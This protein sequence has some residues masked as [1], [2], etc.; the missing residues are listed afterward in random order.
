MRLINIYS[1]S[2][3]L[4]SRFFI[5]LA[6]CFQKMGHGKIYEPI[7]ISKKLYKSNREWEKRWKAI[8]EIIKE[9][10]IKNLMDIGCSEGWFLRRAAEDFSCF[11]IGIEASKPTLMLAETARLYDLVE[12]MAIIKCKLNADTATSLP[13][14]DAILCLSVLHHVVRE[15]G[16]DNARKFLKALATKTNKV[17]IFEMGTSEEHK[18]GWSK[19]MPLMK[20][21]QEKFLITLLSNCGF[22]NIR[23][24]AKT[25]GIK[26]DADRILFAA[27][28]IK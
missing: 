3:G 14:C 12:G 18:L 11:A 22:K 15:N 4:I 7:M 13:K 25:P 17:F 1:G 19:K 21:G 16:F 6:F 9:Y 26:K 28:P 2:M 27:E 5:R 8:S 24:I 23:Q 20:E 10:D